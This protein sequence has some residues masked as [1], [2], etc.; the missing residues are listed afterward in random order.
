M[1]VIVISALT[2]LPPVSDTPMVKMYS[3]VISKSMSTSPV[4]VIIPLVSMEK[5]FPSFPSSDLVSHY[6]SIIISY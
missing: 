4:K 2:V 5:A 1:I 3:G 6:P